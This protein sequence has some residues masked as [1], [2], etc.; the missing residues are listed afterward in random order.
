MAT[1]KGGKRDYDG[2][3]LSWRKRRSADSRWFA[4]ASYSWNDAKGN[5]NSDS[6]ADFQGDWIAL[7]PRAPNQYTTQPGNVE[8]LLKLAG[9]YQ[10]DNGLEVGATYAWNSGTVYTRSWEIYGRHLPEMDDAYE[11]G[12]VVDT[13]VQKGAIG[14][15]ET[16]SYGILNARAKYVAEFG[17]T[18]QVEFFLDVF[19]VLDNQAVTRE[20]DL[21]LGGDGWQF[22][23]ASDWV[24]PRRL[25]LGARMTF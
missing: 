20:Q 15:H 6:N 11:Y 7:D 25:Y 13:W 18:Y 16:P 24:L 14:G 19:N 21:Y 10:W 1:L 23:E 12:G 17:D 8:H 4:L 5:S 3:E 2:V 22:G 9:S